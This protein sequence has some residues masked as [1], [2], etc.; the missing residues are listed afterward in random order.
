VFQSRVE[1]LG[2]DEVRR[3]WVSHATEEI[4]SA[5]RWSGLSTFVRIESTRTIHGQ[6]SVENRYYISSRKRLS[7]KASLAAV[8]EHWSIENQLHWV[9]DVAFA[10]DDSRVRAGNA[11]ANFSAVRQLA[12]GLLKKRTETKVGIKN[13][14]LMAAWD[15]TFLLRVIGLNV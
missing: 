4:A 6:T 12:L 8:R 2:R 11:A 13:R 14:R 1:L 5:E 7:A 3:T 15:D 9:L 10:E